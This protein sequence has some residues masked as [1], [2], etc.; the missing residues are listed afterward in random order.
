MSLVVLL[1]EDEKPAMAQLERAVRA[2][3][4]AVVV[5]GGLSSVRESVD[6]LSTHPAPDLILCDVQL[7]DGL[8]FRIFERVPT[9][10]PVVFCTAYDAYLQDALARCGIDYLLKPLDFPRLHASLDKYLRLRAHFTG[11]AHELSA[12]MQAQVAPRA[13]FVVRRGAEFVAIPVEQVAYFVSEHKLAVL[14][15]RAGRQYALDDSLS[16]LESELGTRRFFRVNRQYLVSP[17]AVVRFR[18]LGKGRL[19]VTLAPATTSEVVVSQ[20]NGAAFRAW[21]NR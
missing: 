13:R 1:I 18:S 7:T 11:R 12:A 4:A 20:E 19:L 6:W 10:A 2:W 5:V 21:L 16:A 15:D 3:D 8:S 9:T 17:S 14:V